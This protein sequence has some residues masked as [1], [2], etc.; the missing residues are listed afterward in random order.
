LTRWWRKRSGQVTWMMAALSDPGHLGFGPH[1]S[2]GDVDSLDPRSVSGQLWSGPSGLTRRPTLS[3]YPQLEHTTSVAVLLSPAVPAGESGWK[4]GAGIRSLGAPRLGALRGTGNTRAPMLCHFACY[5][6][7][8]LP[9]GVW[10][11]SRR[12]GARRTVDRPVPGADSYRNRADSG[13][14]PH[15]SRIRNAKI[16]KFSEREIAAR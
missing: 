1:G 16:R 3:P 12:G 9:P 15:R 14:A 10:C 11:A 7:I 2:P 6:L 5:W 13:V 4:L 8:G